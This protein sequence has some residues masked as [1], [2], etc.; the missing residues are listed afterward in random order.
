MLLVEEP[1][2][3]GSETEEAGLAKCKHVFFALAESMTLGNSVVLR[4]SLVN[5]RTSKVNWHRTIAFD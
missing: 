5:L 2:D 3:Q 1:S 4:C